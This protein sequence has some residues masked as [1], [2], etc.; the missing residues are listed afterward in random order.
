MQDESYWVDRCQS[1]EAKLKTMEE[2]VKPA[3]E[4]V[5]NFKAN[6]GI[7]ETA[8]GEIKIDFDKF[9]TNLG[10]A[11]AL[12]LRSIIDSKYQISGEPGKK[13]RI[14]IVA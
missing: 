13:P 14:K 12:E 4:R 10:V 1:A 2:S 7:K 11:G 9:A 8:S 3:L 6:F 5:K